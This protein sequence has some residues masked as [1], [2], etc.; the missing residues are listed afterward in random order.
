MPALTPTTLEKL[1]RLTAD[2][3][4]GLYD[5][6]LPNVSTGLPVPGPL[7]RFSEVKTFDVKAWAERRGIRLPEV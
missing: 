3:D 5:N 7:E 4:A 6:Q 2:L 1:E